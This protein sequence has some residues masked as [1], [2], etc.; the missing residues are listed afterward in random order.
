VPWSALNIRIGREAVPPKPETTLLGW[1]AWFTTIGIAASTV[2]AVIGAGWALFD[3]L[4][5]RLGK[6]EER[7]QQ[8]QVRTDSTISD[9]RV[10][11]AR[12]SARQEPS[13]TTQTPTH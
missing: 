5:G 1:R 3:N 10:E 6:V 7:V 2:V 4:D 9:V 11:V 12:L 13:K 8:N